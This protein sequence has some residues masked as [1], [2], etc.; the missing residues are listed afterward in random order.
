MVG[1]LLSPASKSTLVTTSCASKKVGL[2]GPWLSPLSSSSVVGGA[3][4]Y[5]CW[6]WG[7]FREGQHQP[8]IGQRTFLGVSREIRYV[9]HAELLR[10]SLP[11]PPAVHGRRVTCM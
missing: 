3:C 10:K 8:R 11:P 2:T 9:R 1:L 5:M 4:I 6:L 7:W